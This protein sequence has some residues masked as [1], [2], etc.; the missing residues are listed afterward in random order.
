MTAVVPF[1]NGSNK[2]S[3][4]EPTKMAGSKEGPMPAWDVRQDTTANPEEETPWYLRLEN[5]LLVCLGALD[6]AL[7][8]AT[9]FVL[10]SY[11]GRLYHIL[12][13]QIV[14]LPGLD[15]VLLIFAIIG[16][17][18]LLS[19]LAFVECMNLGLYH[20]LM[21]ARLM[22]SS[23]P[24]FVCSTIF[25]F[26]CED[27]E[28]IP[29]MSVVT[30]C[31][32]VFVWCLH[33]RVHYSHQLNTLSKIALDVSW[34]LALLFGVMISILYLADGMKELTNSDDNGCPYV[35]NQAMPVH[36][37]SVDEWYCAKWGTLEDSKVFISRE[38]AP[39]PVPILTCSDSFLLAFGVS[40]DAHRFE[41]PSG[42]LRTSGSGA[43]VGCGTY[44]MDS[45]VC[46]S[47]IHAGVMDDA[48]GS[49][50]VF[51]RVGVP[52]FERCSRNAISS[53]ERQVV[54]APGGSVSVSTP[55]GGSSSFLVSSY[56]GR[57]MQISAPLVLASDGSQ[58]PGAFHFNNQASVQEYIWLKKYEEV[59]SRDAGIKAGQ[60]WTRMD[61]IVSARVAGIEVQDEYIR[62]GDPGSR[63]LFRERAAGEG[64]AASPGDVP[65]CSLQASGV[66]CRGAGIAVLELD[67]C[68]PEVKSCLER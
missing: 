36:V 57:R 33:M 54:A 16:T 21:N 39:G 8:Y 47:A 9:W 29:F 59:S 62:L 14:L 52:S 12:D 42:C 2:I 55:A 65:D 64:V 38:P 34:A 63:D 26:V 67:F 48:G 30:T 28:W 10:N 40:I 60:P 13:L 41:C 45:S 23:L 24:C 1:S 66:L 4:P 31:C 50:V 20:E 11:S 15:I 46:L 17:A 53:Y 5:V 22:F 3:K 44:A 19:Q 43:V 51:G 37:L 56:G 68:R 25:L 7:C 6:N 32:Y 35:N 49:G 61:G 27:V 58:V 18:L